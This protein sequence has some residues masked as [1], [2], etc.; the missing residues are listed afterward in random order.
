MSAFGGN[1][2]SQLEAVVNLKSRVV[3]NGGV[4]SAELTFES[5]ED[6]GVGIMATKDIKMGSIL[7]EVPF[8]DCL[9]VEKI[10]QCEALSRIFSEQQGLEEFPDEILAIGLMYGATKKEEC[11]W[12]D[13]IKTLPTADQMNS[14]TFWNEEQ[15]NRLQ[16]GPSIY[17]LT[18]MMNKQC[19]ADWNAVHKALSEVYPDILGEIT[20]DLYK[21]ALS[22]VYSRAVGMPRKGAYTRAIPPIIDLANHD[23][24]IASETAETFNYDEKSEMLQF[25]SASDIN[26][27]D[28]C[29]AVYGPYPNAKLAYTYGFVMHN[30]RHQAVDLWTRVSPNSTHGAH[31]QQILQSHPL[32]SNQTYDFEGTLRPNFISPALLATIRII[33]ANESE[34]QSNDITNAFQGKM[35]SARNEG[36]TYVS[37]RSLLVSRLSPEQYETDRKRLG[38]LL[39]DGASQANREVMALII[40][41]EERDLV[42]SCIVMVDEMVAKLELLGDSYIPIDSQRDSP[43]CSFSNELD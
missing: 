32:T 3:T 20:K 43:S 40:Q 31:K 8:K 2:T 42:K 38:E 19:E 33:N 16:G 6:A 24:T 37:L 25:I 18:S 26:S 28:Q 27:G 10:V 13:H 39:M 4:I 11:A 14:T 29:C 41:T 30:N 36:A 15:L 5:F 34:L 7:M 22:M 17:H 23:P 9:S 35:V 1:S 21:W 12:Y